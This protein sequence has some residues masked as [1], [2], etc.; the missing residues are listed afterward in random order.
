MSK[1]VVL[2]LGN[3]DLN[4]G[5]PAVTAELWE[6]SNP[7]PMKFTG[8]LPAAPDIPELYRAWQLLYCALYSRR[9]WSTRLEIEQADVTNVSEVDFND[10]CLRLSDRINTW[11]NSESF[12]NIN[13]QLRTRLNSSEEIR[14]IIETN[15]KQLR[16][17]PWHLWNFFEDYSKAEVALST[18][19]YQRVEKSSLKKPR[20]IVRILAI[21]G[22]NQGIDIGKDRDLLEQL[23]EQAEIEFL[24][25]PQPELLN[26]TLWQEWDI[27]FFAGHSS[28]RENGVIQLNQTDSLTLGQLRFA[29]KKAIERGLKLAI[30]NSCDG[31]GLAQELAD[32]HIPQVIVMREPVPDAI[33]HEFLKHFLVAFSGGQSL[34][35]SVREARERLQ[36]LE[37]NFPCA[38]WLPAICQ[39]PA[40]VPTTWKEWCSA[41]ERDS[42]TSTAERQQRQIVP[43]RKRFSTL[44]VASAVITALVMGGRWLGILQPVE[45]QAY[46]QLLRLRSDEA[47]DQRLLVVTI[48]ESDFQLSEQQQRKGSI[49]DLA[50]IRL[51]EKLERYKPRAIGL[52]IYRDFPADSNQGNLTSRLEKSDRFFAICKVSMPK[53]NHPGIAPPPEISAERQ[54]FSDFVQDSDGVLRRHLIAMHPDA[55]SPC[56]TPYALSARLAFRYLED[57]GIVAKYTP[58]Q[59]LQLGKVIFK[60]LRSRMGSYQQ[61]DDWGYQLLLNYRR[62][63]HS[64]LEVAEKVTLKDVL[65]G[66]V[67]PDKV[68]DRIILIGVTAESSGDRFVTPYSTGQGTY[69]PMPGVIVHAQMVSQM[70]SAVKD[71]RVLLWVCP[72]WGDVLWVWGWSVVGGVVVWRFGS[73]RWLGV[74]SGVTLGVLCGLSFG[75]FTQG[76]WVPLVPA[77]IALV[78]TGRTILAYGASQQEPHKQISITQE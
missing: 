25:E 27:L 64:P 62:S 22:N 18:S 34:Y 12:R 31:L 41:K 17:L 44:L 8:S 39:N 7:Y 77:A 3:G 47:Q 20:A 26:D 73:I 4:N 45:L 68:K 52:D 35:T 10:L 40:E 19:E 14:F 28:S 61:V 75:F 23:S 5:F 60:R 36:K 72:W 6:V 16:R 76:V 9:G 49:S 21:L 24:V 55:T 78:A 33:A 46:D 1:L 59:E 30:F 53:L 15:D 2:S 51:L 50:L 11:L 63:Y 48:T 67:Q 56:T 13:E 38:T 37:R 42:A 70:L 69:E 66:K 71:G 32:M 54:G 58:Q 43:S 29:L 57:E 74:A 65:A